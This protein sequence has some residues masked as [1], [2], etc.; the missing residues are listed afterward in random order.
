MA[1]KTKI[2][3]LRLLEERIKA[4]INGQ[5][6]NEIFQDLT[7]AKILGFINGNTVN[8]IGLAGQSL[9]DTDPNLRLMGF[10]YFKIK[11]A[12]EEIKKDLMELESN[13]DDASQNDKLGLLSDELSLIRDSFLIYYPDVDTSSGV[14]KSLW[15]RNGIVDKPPKLSVLDCN[16][17]YNHSSF[18][19]VTT[20][21]KLNLKPNEKANCFKQIT[22]SFCKE[23]KFS[24]TLKN[25]KFSTNSLASKTLGETLYD[26]LT[27]PD[28]VTSIDDILDQTCSNKQ[29]RELAIKKACDKWRNK[30]KEQR[31]PLEFIIGI[32]DSQL[33]LGD[34]LKIDVEFY[35][36]VQLNDS[37]SLLFKKLLK[38]L[39]QNINLCE[40]A[41][42]DNNSI[43]LHQSKDL[44]FC[45]FKPKQLDHLIYAVYI[46]PK[47]GVDP[48]MPDYGKL[49]KTRRLLHET[50]LCSTDWP[51]F[52]IAQSIKNLDYQNDDQKKGYLC[53]IHMDILDKSGIKGGFKNVI[54]GTYTYHH[55]MQN[56]MNDCGW[57]CAYRSLQTII[58]WYKHQGYIYSPDTKPYEPS[59]RGSDKIVELRLRLRTENR[60]PNHD[61][62]QLTLQDIGMPEFMGTKKWIGSQE[63]CFVLDHLYGISSKFIAVSSGSDLVT[64]ARDLGSHFKE[65]STPIMIGG[66]VLAHTIIGVDFNEKNGD[67]SYLILDPHYTES[68]DLDKIL[69]KGWCG[70]KKNSFWEKSAFYN[71]CLPQRPL[72]KIV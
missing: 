27:P 12:D 2:Q 9:V 21:I 15:T 53:N 10:V 57:G 22:N 59:K 32:D 35:T 60:V 55:Y 56:N 49:E 40:K 11:P 1:N 66:G 30:Y 28:E 72:D 47:M 42:D 58:S 41:I 6:N 36:F 3:I 8:Y 13:L 17:I 67:I 63:V 48:A 70:W 68:E 38:T 5:E 34:G 54:N 71:L 69:K 50:Y 25:S 64:K 61:E 33:E 4:I 20:S 43:D 37:L 46:M 45:T 65:H 62:I 39:L 23:N 44:I 24:I 26:H 7:K 31:G 19:K 52:R 18:S 16:K 14:S 29:E 51:Q